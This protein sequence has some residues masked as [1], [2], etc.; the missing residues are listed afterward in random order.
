MSTHENFFTRHVVQIISL[1]IG[2]GSVFVFWFSYQQTQAIS[3]KNMLNEARE[4][5]DGVA[6]FRTF[7]S[8]SVVKRAREQGIE[9]SHDYLNDKTKLPL[10][11]TLSMDFGKYLASANANYSVRLYSDQPFPW[12]V[13]DG[14][15][16]PK[17]DFE[18]WAMGELRVN[19]EKPVWRIEQKGAEQVLRYARADRLEASCVNCHN[20]YPGTPK[21]SWKEGDV[22][23]VLAVSRPMGAI[24][25]ESQR[26]MMQSFLMLACLGATLLLIL[27]MTLRGMRSSL[28]LAQQA[29][30]QFRV[31]NQKLVLGLEEREQLSRDLLTSQTKTRAIVDS[32]LDAIVVINSKGIIIETNPAVMPVFGYSPEELV[33]KNISILMDEDH[34]HKHDQYL[35]T[36]SLTGRPHII[37][38]TRQLTVKHKNGNLFPI[39]LAVNEARVGDSSIFTGVIRD[40]THRLQAQD[41]LAKAHE[42][43]LQSARLKSEF[44]A[45]MSHE[46]RTPMNGVIGMTS[47]LLDSGL[48]REQRDL[49]QTVLHSAESLLRIINDILD[50]SKIE[51]GKLTISNSHFALLPIIESIFDLLGEQAYNKGIELAYFIDR[52][53]PLEIDSDPIRIRQILINL[54]NNAIKFTDRGYVLLSITASPPDPNNQ[55]LLRFEVHDSGCGIPEDAQKMLFQA[56]TQVDGS[57]TRQHGGT[58]LGLTICKK[59]THLMGGEVGLRSKHGKGSTF[60]ATVRAGVITPNTLH[61]LENMSILLLGNSR[62]LNNYYDR[63]LQHWGM[64]SVVANTLNSLFIALEENNSFTFIALDADMVYH[65]PEHPLGMISVINTIREY[66][67]AHI[68]IYGSNRQLEPLRG[69][70]MGR[71]IHLLPKPLKHSLIFNYLKHLK[72]HPSEQASKTD[73]KQQPQLLAVPKVMSQPPAPPVPSLLESKADIRILLTEDHLV[74]QKVAIAILRKLGYTRVDCAE[75]GEQALQ[76]VQT[77]AYDL[78]LMDCQMPVMDGYEATRTIRKLDNPQFQRLPIIALTAHTM[79]GDDEKCYLAGMNDYLSKPVRP[80]ELGKKL[81]KWLQ[82][83]IKTANS[84]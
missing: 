15:G 57:S 74:N 11:A 80:D 60:W 35:E 44:L 62:T 76:A 77:H 75:N 73:T 63:Q 34:A 37:G 65:K 84:V 22:R 68:I 1:I 5:A 78:V 28:N 82:A 42:A 33:G 56:F 27:I 30:R 48:N 50:V 25:H 9:F 13:A 39:E 52:D 21:T 32:I 53:V 8:N 23:G 24:V 83:R 59:L 38:S 64:L 67:N 29:E 61:P 16:G 70:K 72:H 58:G 47:L 17:D 18:S 45:N 54:I 71:H 2:V 51:A 40:I 81:E 43:A 31:T 46:I 19:P 12:R 69:V 4:F 36:Y 3:E 20:T 14:S 26:A 79:K 7:Y 66:S 55:T 6:H 10:P 49:T 41:E